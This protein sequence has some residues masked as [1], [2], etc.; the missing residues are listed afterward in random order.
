MRV[1]LDVLFKKCLGG[2]P[3]PGRPGRARLGT[4]LEP[5]LGSTALYRAEVSWRYIIRTHWLWFYDPLCGRTL[6]RTRK[7]SYASC[8]PTVGNTYDHAYCRVLRIR[9]EGLSKK[10]LCEK[11][12][13]PL[14]GRTHPRTRE[15]PCAS[16]TW[17]TGVNLHDKSGMSIY[18]TNLYQML[19]YND[20]WDPG[21]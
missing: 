6:L 10:S 1:R 7:N 17:G 8:V 12:L 3:R 16:T 9:L 20:E 21:V 19:L 18:S 15:K 11:S 13:C 14:V 4:T 5:L 2:G